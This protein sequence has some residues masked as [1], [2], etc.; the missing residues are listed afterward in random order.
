VG[1]QA[2]RVDFAAFDQRQLLH[3][4]SRAEKDHLCLFRPDPTTLAPKSSESTPG[5]E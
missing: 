5:A 4:A 1:E 2:D 3:L